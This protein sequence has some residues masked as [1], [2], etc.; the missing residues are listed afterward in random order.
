[1]I[2][3]SV[4][5]ADNVGSNNLSVSEFDIFALSVTQTT[6][7]AGSGNGAA[8]ASLFL[9]GADVAFNSASEKLDGITLTVGPQND[10]PTATIT[11]TSYAVSENTPLALHGTGL[12]VSDPDAGTNGVRVTLTVGEGTL[13]VAPGTPGV[14]ITNSGTASVT[15]EGT[16]TQ[17][18]TLL[19][20]DLGA[21]MTY[22]AVE[23]PSA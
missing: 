15:L 8:T 19:A 7:V 3:L 10:A 14:P 6:F 17:L 16:L 18:N 21:T 1:T 20:G 12:T 5:A 9:E 11:P 22:Q 23:D 2:L 4:D 13:T